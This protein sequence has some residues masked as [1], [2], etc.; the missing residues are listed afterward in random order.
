MAETYSVL[1]DIYMTSLQAYIQI[2][3]FAALVTIVSKKKNE[4]VIIDNYSFDLQ[5][6]INESG[7]IIYP[8]SFAK[9]IISVIQAKDPIDEIILLMSIKEASFLTDHP[10][11]TQNSK[12]I[13]ENAKDYLE[14][15][16]SRPA[17]AFEI[18]WVH[19]GDILDEGTSAYTCMLYYCY[20][21]REIKKMRTV[22][23][24]YGVHVKTTFVP[25]LSTVA[26]YQQYINDYTDP[27]TIIIES[28]FSSNPNNCT[29]LYEFKRNVLSGF[30]TD[31]QGFFYS[32]SMIQ[33]QFNDKLSFKNIYELLMTCGASKE[34]APEDA[35]S[36]LELQGISPELWY[37]TTEKAFHNFGIMLNNVTLKQATKFDNVYLTGPM[38]DIP[39]I[40]EY[41]LNRYSVAVKVWR[42]SHE[43]NIGGV[44]FL[45]TSGEKVPSI[46][47]GLISCIYYEQYLRV[48]KN[49][50]FS[51]KKIE[52]NLDKNRRY[53][54]GVLGASIIFASLLCTPN[55]VRMRSIQNKIADLQQ[56]TSQAN[57]IQQEIDKISSNIKVQESFLEK[58]KSSI[59][60]LNFIYSCTLLKPA[61]VTIISIDTSNFVD[62]TSTKPQAYYQIK[63]AVEAKRQEMEG[64][65]IYDPYTID[66]SGKDWTFGLPWTDV[67]LTEHG[68]AQYLKEN[69]IFNI[70]EYFVS[71][72]VIRGYGSVSAIA[73][74]S[75]DLEASANVAR[76]DVVGIESKNINDGSGKVVNTNVFEFDVWFGDTRH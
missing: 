19:S 24:K 64:T 12:E 53:F 8:M 49:G 47:S 46:Y 5:K 71:K 69:N 52:I 27:N 60:D 67:E 61:E 51:K 25:E 58:S 72:V 34:T 1:S 44:S 45:Y 6:Y 23:E 33:S 48:V 56:E 40:E 63:K 29:G 26:L 43:V 31:K 39:G 37:A 22:F 70:N 75:K 76:V 11:Y 36:M 74:Y 54:L 16:F 30:K 55:F 3:N 66:I 15:K 59:F 20:P 35:T 62:D 14:Q 4:V 32:V 73:R 57:A 21:I 38:G 2:T 17:E 18:G 7:S 28:G 50:T 42:I 68:I 13:S 10:E 41:L 65:G 9:D